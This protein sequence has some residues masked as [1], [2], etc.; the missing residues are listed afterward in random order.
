MR[1]QLTPAPRVEVMRADQR[2]CAGDT[3]HDAVLI[4]ENTTPPPASSRLKTWLVDALRHLFELSPSLAM[5][6]GRFIWWMLP[7]LKEE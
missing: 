5:R 2:S 6:L 1:E 3:G 4:F 7:W